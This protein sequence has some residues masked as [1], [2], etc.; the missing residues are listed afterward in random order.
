MLKTGNNFAKGGFTLIE[1]MAATAVLS[2]GIVFLY[3]AFFIS[4]DVF[5]YYANYI[6][7]SSWM[8]EQIWQA[9]DQ[10]THY[11]PEARVLTGGDVIKA[12]TSFR[13]NLSYNL[14]SNSLYRIQYMLS[15]NKGKKTFNLTREA[16]A[17]YEGR[18]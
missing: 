6:H 12:G 2:L 7:V 13:W 9:L 16:Y 1:I 4:L 11:G 3:E 18:E 10:L 15:W 14:E 17:L 8:D 5:S